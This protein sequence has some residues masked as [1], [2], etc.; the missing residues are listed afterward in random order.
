MFLLGLFVLILIVA[1]TYCDSQCDC[2]SLMD[3]HAFIRTKINQI[4]FDNFKI[5]S[6]LRRLEVTQRHFTRPTD[7][8]TNEGN[9]N[10]YLS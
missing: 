1:F 9:Y 8:K 5:K 7:Q 10:I 2:N 4:E 3:E 6:R